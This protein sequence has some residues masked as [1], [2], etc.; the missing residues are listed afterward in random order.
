MALGGLFGDPLGG[1]EGKKDAKIG[2]MRR[3]GSLALEKGC[4]KHIGQCLALR[5]IIVLIKGIKSLSE[6]MRN[7]NVYVG[8]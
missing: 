5:G 1:K 2:S 4:F 7:L 3:N 8:W 6:R